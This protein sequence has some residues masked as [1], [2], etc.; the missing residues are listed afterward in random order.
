MTYVIIIS[1]TLALIAVYQ[2]NNP[3]E[4]VGWLSSILWSVYSL[5]LLHKRKNKTVLG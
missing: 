2:G 5:V 4:I 1:I 3:S